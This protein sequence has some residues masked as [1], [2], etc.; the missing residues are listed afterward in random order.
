MAF[1]S[2]FI[3]MWSLATYS[4]FVVRT[5]TDQKYPVQNCTNFRAFNHGGV[6]PPPNRVIIFNFTCI[7]T[8]L[9]G[10]E[11]ITKQ[12]CVVFCTCKYFILINWTFFSFP[13]PPQTR[14]RV[15]LLIDIT[16]I[17][18]NKKTN[19]FWISHKKPKWKQISS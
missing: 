16:D 12:C 11:N 14:T 3:I 7:Q 8:D 13:P 18:N 4:S 19:S 2:F 15:K 6:P 17:E 9:L 10:I 1:H 5:R